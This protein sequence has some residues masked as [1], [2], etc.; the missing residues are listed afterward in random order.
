VPHPADLEVLM[1]IAA[2]Y[3]IAAEGI[4]FAKL[5]KEKLIC[6]TIEVICSF[7]IL[8]GLKDI[9][10]KWTDDPTLIAAFA[11]IMGVI[12]VLTLVVGL[13]K[14]A[15]WVFYRKMKLKLSS[16][17]TVGDRFITSANPWKNETPNEDFLKVEQSFD[18]LFII[19]LA[20]LMM[21]G[22]LVM[23]SRGGIN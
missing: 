6:A 8:Y 14:E 7:G 13:K 16:H 2:F 9:F 11:V 18:R 12:L 3:W 1:G 10:L 23:I 17:L 19:T 20:A 15:F 4:R 22:V 5:K 21:L